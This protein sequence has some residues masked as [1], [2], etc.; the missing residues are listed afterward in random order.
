MSDKLTKGIKLLLPLLLAVLLLTVLVSGSAAGMPKHPEV[1]FEELIYQR[2]DAEA[3]LTDI[4]AAIAELR[5]GTPY[6]RATALLDSCFDG[7]DR[8]DTMLTLANIRS[9]QDG[10]DSFYA[11]EYAWGLETS[12]KVSQSID[13]LYRTCAETRY[14]ERL[15]REYFWDGFCLDYGEGSGISDRAV[16]LMQREGELI[17]QYRALMA[18]PTILLDGYE[19]RLNDFLATAGGYDT[20]KATEAFYRQYNERAS[21]LYIALVRLRHELA[22]ELGYDSYEQM[23]YLDFFRRDYDSAAADDYITEVRTKLLPLYEEVMSTNPYA[24]LTLEALSEQRL[25]E[26]VRG[27]AERM[28]DPV[29][30]AFGYMSRN[31]LWDT[32]RRRTKQPVSFEIYLT[33]FEAPF[34]FLD[35][36][37]STD[38]VFSLLHELGHYTDDYVSFAAPESTDLSECFS[39][40]LELLAL[41]Y[42]GEPL[43]ETERETLV[44]LKLLDTLDLYVQ[45]CSFAEFE[46]EVYAMPPEE[47]SAERLN[48]LSL[49]LAK[50][51]GYYDGKSE[52]YYSLGWFDILHFFEQ[53]FYV[54]SYPVT[55]DAA[56][57]LFALELEQS[58]QGTERYRELLERRSD[59]LLDSLERAGL[60]S[61]FAP[62]RVENCASLLRALLIGE[63]T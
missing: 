35:P 2:P 14:A 46:R 10:E 29:A 59:S 49:R 8:F 23:Q 63:K 1:P 45:Q 47:L 38:D 17:G 54:I 48:A 36:S 34:L 51:Y 42:L 57:Q 39:Q 3:L 40:S 9:C 56:M 15:E 43:S 50:E 55:N 61:P 37:G 5:A 53:P 22:A 32:E 18:D 26:A 12:G 20:L 62:G 27:C 30:E 16:E 28:G 33:A 19:E 44:R 41:G 58:G 11:E 4:D 24:E 21:E 52:D 25:R 60:E 13:R 7:F 6:R 31:S